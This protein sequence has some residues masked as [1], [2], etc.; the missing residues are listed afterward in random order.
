M[1]LIQGR[2]TSECIA[3]REAAP[4]YQEIEALLRDR[5]DAM[6]NKVGWQ[7]WRGEVV[8]RRRV[9]YGRQTLTVLKCTAISLSICW[10]KEGQEM[11]RRGLVVGC[12]ESCEADGV[13]C[14][15]NLCVLGLGVLAPT[16]ARSMC[17]LAAINFV[18]G[19]G[20]NV[21]LPFPRVQSI[22]DRIQTEFRFNE[23]SLK[24][25]P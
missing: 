1:H 23:E 4:S 20:M 8:L 19:N 14:G 21:S 2:N 7:A 10:I 5:P 24:Q 18:S 13:L 16:H 11:G 3:T 6:M 25:Q 22:F 9:G 17:I 15:A 12:S